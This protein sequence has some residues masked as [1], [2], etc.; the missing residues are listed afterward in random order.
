[1]RKCNKHR[2]HNILTIAGM[3]K[4]FAG[5]IGGLAGAITTTIL[6]EILR[7]RYSGAPRLDK[8]GEEALDK[9]VSKISGNHIPAEKKY[10][11]SMA[12]D[13]VSNTLYYSAAAFKPARAVLT[14]TIL[15]ATAG[16]GAVKLPGRM[17]LNGSTTAGTS[18]RKWL[19]IGLYTIGGLV[20]GLVAKRLAANAVTAS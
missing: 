17:G 8:L 15:G 4:K 3:N 7:R 14:G 13:I 10:P 16:M 19:T 2:W 20:A 5:L 18:N 12:A 1:V 11:A 6:H 9:T